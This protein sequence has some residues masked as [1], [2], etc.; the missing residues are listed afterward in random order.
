MAS[1]T[2]RKIDDAVYER[3]RDRARANKRSAEAEVRHLIAET[4]RPKPD[5]TVLVEELRRFQ[6][7][8]KAK[9]GVLSDST[10]LIRQMRD[11]E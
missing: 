10:E 3:L 8:M 5:M 4:V 1:L 7:Q 6:A 2:I 11:E 9:Y